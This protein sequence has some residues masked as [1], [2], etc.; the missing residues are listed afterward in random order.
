MPPVIFAGGQA[1]TIQGQYA[2]PHPDCHGLVEFPASGLQIGN[3]AF[4]WFK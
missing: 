1:Y 3:T 2:I 4:K